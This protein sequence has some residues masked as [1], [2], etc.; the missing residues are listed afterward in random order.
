MINQN[1]KGLTL[2]ELLA[3]IVISAILLFFVTSIY[4]NAL[5][6][7]ENIKAETELRNEADLFLTRMTRIIYVSNDKDITLTS[8]ETNKNYYLSINN[9]ISGYKDKKVY[10]GGELYSPS[11]N[12]QIV[13]EE[14]KI[15]RTVNENNESIYT[16]Q[17]TL[18]GKKGI[19]KTF[20]TNVPS[21]KSLEEGST[22]D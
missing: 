14:S 7:Y 8:D 13:W 2:V 6:N 5:G 11:K 19:K 10:V 20:T 17:L 22:S 16:V 12:A 4:I 18:K 21:I 3:V 1:E 15:T 9:A